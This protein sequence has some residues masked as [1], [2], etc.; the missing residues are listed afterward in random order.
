MS[1]CKHTEFSSSSLTCF[2][3]TQPFDDFACATSLASA[4]PPRPSPALDSPLSLLLS[5]CE[6]LTPSGAR[7]TI[8]TT[9][10]T[11][12]RARGVPGTCCMS[13]FNNRLPS[14]FTAATASAA[15]GILRRRCCGQKD[16]KIDCQ[17]GPRDHRP[18]TAS[19]VNK[20]GL[21]RQRRRR[22][23]TAAGIACCCV[24]EGLTA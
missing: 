24:G 17:T 10:T 19:G 1:L 16:H 21:K 4:P 14:L 13:R 7:H 2:Q 9:T 18:C 5:V 8:T 15:T 22:I 23:E 6:C 20:R 3:A 11:S 12:E